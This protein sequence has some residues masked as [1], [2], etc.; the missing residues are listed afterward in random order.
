MGTKNCRSVVFLFPFLILSA[1]LLF[2]KT[3]VQSACTCL[4]RPFSQISLLSTW[5]SHRNVG[6]APELVR[7]REAKWIDIMGQWNHILLKKTSKVCAWRAEYK[8][9]QC[10]KNS[11]IWCYKGNGFIKKPHACHMLWAELVSQ[12]GLPFRSRCSV[13]KAS[14]L[15]SEQSAG[16]CCVE[17]PTG[18][19]KMKTCTR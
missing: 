7:Q 8:T 1:L 13:K 9:S 3:I 2:E 14:Q 19:K 11:H 12:C 6:P 17:R 18:W 5:S 4:H 16:L 10:T 15:H